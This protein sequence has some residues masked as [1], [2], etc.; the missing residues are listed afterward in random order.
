MVEQR[1]NVKIIEYSNDNYANFN[2]DRKRINGSYQFLGDQPDILVQ[3]ED[4]SIATSIVEAEYPDV[5]PT[6]SEFNNN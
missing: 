2:I 6:S 1:F 4:T 5:V 3:Q